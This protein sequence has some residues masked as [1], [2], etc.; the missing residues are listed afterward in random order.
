MDSAVAEFELYFD[1]EKQSQLPQRVFK[2]IADLLV[3]LGKLES[4]LAQTADSALRA[5]LVLADVETGSIPKT[6]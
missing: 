4:L 5:E 6:R 1:F 3:V 2:T